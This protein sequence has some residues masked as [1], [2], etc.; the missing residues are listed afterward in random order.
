MMLN[1]LA[2]EDKQMVWRWSLRA[3]GGSDGVAGGGVRMLLR[4]NQTWAAPRL[5]VKSANATGPA[6]SAAVPGPAW[7]GVSLVTVD[8][9]AH[10]SLPAFGFDSVSFDPV[11]AL[12]LI[13]TH[14]RP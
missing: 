4:W 7:G 9:P 1:T 2:G 14:T 8:L 12:S 11:P 3:E 6:I 13:L 5:H 10:D